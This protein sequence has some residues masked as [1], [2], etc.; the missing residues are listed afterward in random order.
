MLIGKTRPRRPRDHLSGELPPL[1]RI[2]P[3]RCRR[4][5]PF[6][7][8]LTAADLSQATRRLEQNPGDLTES[9]GPTAPFRSTLFL[10]RN[11]LRPVDGFTA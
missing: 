1:E 2:V 10:S 8:R 4:A 6:V 9:P 7:R 11:R 3:V 5:R